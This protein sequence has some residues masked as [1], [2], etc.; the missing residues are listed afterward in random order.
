MK[1]PVV[2]AIL[3]IL[4]PII[5][6]ARIGETVEQCIQRYGEPVKELAKQ[7][8]FDKCLLFEN[9]GFSFRIGFS[10]G[11]ATL[12][13][14]VKPDAKGELCP[15]TD[16]EVA[17]IMKVN[18]GD[19][20]WQQIED[21]P[22]RISYRAGNGS[23]CSEYNKQQ[24]VLFIGVVSPAPAQSKP[25]SQG[26]APASTLTVEEYSKIMN[27]IGALEA[28]DR[29]T[30]SAEKRREAGE[31]QA[32]AAGFPLTG[33]DPSQRQQNLRNWQS[34]QELEELRSRRQ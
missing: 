16:A 7:G 13:T 25:S 2:A 26:A 34:K 11:I 3:L 24:H 18:F 5:A 32:A 29:R 17:G 20:S 10:K 1:T 15:L 28:S 8:D 9:K 31:A 14:F 12:I 23:L 27:L 6:F 21:S 30:T 4:T 19:Q 33:V 22:E